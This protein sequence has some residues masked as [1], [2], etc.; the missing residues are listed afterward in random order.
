MFGTD[1]WSG[2]V[3]PESVKMPVWLAN[4][5][6]WTEFL[7]MYGERVTAASEQEQKVAAD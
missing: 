7:G 2:S 3:E 5:C 1:I 4:T 6:S